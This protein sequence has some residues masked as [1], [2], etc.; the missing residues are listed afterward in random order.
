MS[1]EQK[2]NKGN[3]STSSRI[4]CGI[5]GFCLLI[6]IFLDLIG[7]FNLIQSLHEIEQVSSTVSTALKPAMTE[8]SV[9]SILKII[10]TIIGEICG[11]V[12]SFT[13]AIKD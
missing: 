9:L 7:L 11:S 10:F 12:L 5:L 1:K 3:K 2:I 8:S 6:V 4:F 13:Y